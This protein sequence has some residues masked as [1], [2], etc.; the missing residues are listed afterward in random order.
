MKLKNLKTPETQRLI[1][2]NTSMDDVSLIYALR[3]SP[4]VRKYIM[5]PLFT[6]KD[7]AI[8]HVNKLIGFL[9]NDKSISWTLIDKASNKKL[10]GICLWNFSEDR[11][12]A[13]VGYDLL[14]EYFK[15]GY[16]SEALQAV[17]KFGFSALDLNKIEAFTHLENETSKKLLITN[18]FTL[19]P[20]R[21]DPGF[22]H[23][24]IYTLE[25]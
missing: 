15:K 13:E 7:E 10:G 11:K 6:T 18:G 1:F 21:E 14:P 22:P 3:S 20:E 16:M 17:I 5:Q 2:T 9:D 23:N 24:I 4:I 19:K 8:A 12:T 25:K